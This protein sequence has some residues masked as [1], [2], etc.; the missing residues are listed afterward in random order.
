M[1]HL[2][3]LPATVLSPEEKNSAQS[4]SSAVLKETLQTS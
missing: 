4:A 2:A 1:V 3:N